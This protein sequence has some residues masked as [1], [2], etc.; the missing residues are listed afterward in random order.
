MKSCK[1]C[2]EEYKPKTSNQKYCSGCKGKTSRK[3]KYW[4]IFNRDKFRC[5][6]CGK[7]SIEDGILL[8]C[9]HI[10]PKAK[11]GDYNSDSNLVTSCSKCNLQKNAT[12]MDKDIIDRIRKTILNR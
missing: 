5:I 7:S 2:G 4:H 1:D 12:I 8:H 11:G 6:Y 9:D 10:Y 3:P